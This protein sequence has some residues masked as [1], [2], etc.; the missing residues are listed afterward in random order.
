MREVYYRSIWWGDSTVGKAV[1]CTVS[2]C[3]GQNHRPSNCTNNYLRP[4]W[5]V[6]SAVIHWHTAACPCQPSKHISS[7]LKCDN[8]NVKCTTNM[9]PC[10]LLHCC[11]YYFWP[12]ETSYYIKKKKPSILLHYQAKTTKKKK[13]TLVHQHTID[14][15]GTVDH[16]VCSM[17][18]PD[19][20]HAILF[21]VESPL[22]S[23]NKQSNNH[24]DFKN[25][26]FASEETQQKHFNKTEHCA[27]Y[28]KCLCTAS[29]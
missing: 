9:P 2:S 26:P 20:I 11:C 8:L 5:A 18:V 28:L 27:I 29:I 25:N 7:Y 21:T 13:N 17:C 16:S 14:F 19:Q 1:T 15:V 23:A 22:G 12:C 24:M 4:K 10:L 3:I 6:S